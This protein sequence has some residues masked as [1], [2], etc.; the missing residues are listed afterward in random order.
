VIVIARDELGMTEELAGLTIIDDGANAGDVKFRYGADVLE[1][2]RLEK[3]V[4]G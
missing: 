1:L 4:V 2:A 3:A